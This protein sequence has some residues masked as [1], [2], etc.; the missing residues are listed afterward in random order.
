MTLSKKYFNCAPELTS[1]MMIWFEIEK[2]VNG[3]A[4]EP[5]SV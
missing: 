3:K 1:L 5:S 4:A 2:E